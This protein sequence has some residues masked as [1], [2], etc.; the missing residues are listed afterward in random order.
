MRGVMLA[1]AQATPEALR[2]WKEQ[3]VNAAALLL[4]EGQRSSTVEAGA[5]EVRAAG[6]ELYYW[7]EI[8]RNPALAKAH[9]EWM[10][11]LQGHPE[12][13]RHFPKAP[14]PSEGEIVKCYPWV[15]VFYQEAFGAHLKRV[16]RLLEG[17][18][19]PKGVFL[20]D[21]QA[22]PSACGCGNILC[23]FT[24]DYGPVRTATHLPADAAARFVAAVANLTPATVIPVW[25][26]ECEEADAAEDG[27]CSGVGCF[28]G[29][30]WY[31]WTEQVMPIAR[32]CRTLAALLPY[33]AFDRDLPRYGPTAGWVAHALR[34]FAR[35]PPRRGGEAIPADRLI[36]VLQGWD[37]TGAQVEAQLQRADEAGA[38][39][40]LLA[41]TPIEQGW[42]PRIVPVLPT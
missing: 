14:V 21:L 41:M 15:P 31:A 12:W 23:R 38:A 36:A 27:A 40:T 42:E 29:R 32:R 18:P 9:P 11:S 25:T 20:N 7:I 1:A 34:S 4:T 24:P 8:G 13:R 3:G 6:L 28:E 35:M 39:G 19:A 2:R 37:V 10:A 30:C 16:E 26:P 22:A 5:R 33:R 17:K